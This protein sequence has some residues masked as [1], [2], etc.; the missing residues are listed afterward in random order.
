MRLT[1]FTLPVLI[2]ASGLLLGAANKDCS[3]LKDPGQFTSDVER[4]RKDR[5]DLTGKVA[6]YVS[7]ALLGDQYQP[8]VQT[9]AAAAIPRKNFIDDAVFSRMAT[10]GIQSAPLASDVEFLRRVTLDLTGRIPSGA[11]VVTFTA[12]TNPSKRDA[13]VDELI[14]SP[15]FIDRWTMFFGDL[16][17]V[18]AVSTN[19]NRDVAG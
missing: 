16:F 15:E 10:A 1:W 6:M 2:L 4:S 7:S 14:G 9:F 17:K 5:S 12:D 3:F 11:D 19:I 13:K 8:T 18:N